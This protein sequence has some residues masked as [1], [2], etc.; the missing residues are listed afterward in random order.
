MAIAV[1]ILNIY[2]YDATNLLGFTVPECRTLVCYIISN[3][4]GS[5]I[6]RL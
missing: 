1:E 4:Q 3:L 2:R 6:L 5:K